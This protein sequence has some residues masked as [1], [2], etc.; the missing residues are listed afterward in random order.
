[1]IRR[2][3]AV[4]VLAPLLAAP[5]AGAATTV[6]VPS[7][8]K[9]LL[10]FLTPVNS[11]TTKQGTAV[12]FSVASDVIV[13]R[14]VV[15]RRGAPA[16]GIVTAVSQPGRF[17]KNARVHI[18]GVQATAVDSRPVALSPLDV[19]PNTVRQVKDV[20][21]AAGSSVVGA[22]VLGPIG[23]AAGALVKGGQVSVPAG[24]IGTDAVAHTIRVAAQ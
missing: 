9:V 3:V 10:K 22:I 12:R 5:A 14:H 19:T 23:L 8:T 2:L 6:T 24:A 16:R 17:G 15:I 1:M 18:D 21:A 13:N 4:A 11:A 7:G 20:G